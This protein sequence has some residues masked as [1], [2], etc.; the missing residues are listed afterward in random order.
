MNRQRICGGTAAALITFFPLFPAANRQ[1]AIG[2]RA[3]LTHR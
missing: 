1:P 2:G 3:E